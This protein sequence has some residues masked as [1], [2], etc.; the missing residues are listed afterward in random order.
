[1]A[2][3]GDVVERRS[4]AVRTI[5]TRWVV[6]APIPV[7]RAGFGFLFGG[8][9]MLL[10]HRGRI[11]G[12]RRYTV[13]EVAEHESATSIVVPSGFGP[14]AQWLQNLEA[15]PHCG[16]SVGWRTRVPAVAT[17]LDDAEARVKL[18]K[19]GAEHPVLWP[20]LERMMAEATGDD[21]PVIPLVRLE[22]A[23]RARSGSRAW[24]IATARV[25]P[26]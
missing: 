10:E 22:F 12:K 25:S 26:I 3:N 5:T 17:V 19:Y 8:R 15:E 4:F 24:R 13:L 14:R 23:E 7:F 2:H 16:V 21:P 18:A 6:R 9:L 20:K 1:M 11:S